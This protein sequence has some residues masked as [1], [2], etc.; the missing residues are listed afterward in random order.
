M[1][2]QTDRNR[3]KIDTSYE[4][5]LPEDE[6]QEF[7]KQ[8]E[9]IKFGH[10]TRCLCGYD[11]RN[12]PIVY[13]IPHGDGWTIREEKEKVWLYVKCPKCGYDMAIWK[14]GVPRE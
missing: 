7:R 12:E 6:A 11:L 14:M 8:Y 9:S 3:A 2:K 13:Y 10:G 5:I 4:K 1:I